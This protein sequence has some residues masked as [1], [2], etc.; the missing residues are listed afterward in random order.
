MSG[1]LPGPGPVLV[2]EHEPDSPPGLFARWLDARGI[3]WERRTL[4]GGIPDDPS[5]YG[6]VVTLGSVRSVNDADRWIAAELALV[7]AALAAD[8]PVLG[9]CFGGQMLAKAAGGMVGV[10]PEEEFGW[11]EPVAA[12]GP[13]PAHGL[14]PPTAPTPITSNPW[15][16]W[17]GDAFTVPPGG[18]L[19]ADGPVC[20]Q[21]FAIGRSLG[22]QFHPECDAAT[23]ALWLEQR[24]Q[25]HRPPRDL[26]PTID[27]IPGRLAG[28]ESRAFELFDW[29]LERTRAGAGA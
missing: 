14:D 4:A 12:P 2:L 27:A 25:P 11:I 26:Q 24:A 8:V 21:A 3:A 28:L 13:A 19:L 29:W 23:M 15:F 16:C 20:P 1:P 18:T 5:A 7:R 6:A 17:H 22:V 10:S 9:F